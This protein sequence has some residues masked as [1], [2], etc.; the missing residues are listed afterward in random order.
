MK[1]IIQFDLAEAAET[2]RRFTKD[3]CN[4]VRIAQAAELMAETLKAGGKII[5]CGNGGSLCDATHFAEE[6]TARYRGNRRG[7]PA[8]AVNDP[9]FITCTGNDFSFD[10]IFARFIEAVGAPGDVLL[11]ISTSGNSGNV[12][13]AAK[14]AR[15]KGIR[16]VSLTGKD[17]GELALLSDVDI[18]APNTPYSDRVQEIHIKVIH[19]L[20][21]LIERELALNQ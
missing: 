1:D 21:N 3:E 6:L 14:V 4:A 19:I 8:I 11:A 18:R 10:Y 12:N 15:E 16:V 17:G 20:V 9:A 5:S 2:L 7:L 13:R